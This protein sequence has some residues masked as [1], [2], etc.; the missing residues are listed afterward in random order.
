M[1]GVCI[2][3]HPSEL[4]MSDLNYVRCLLIPSS[5]SMTYSVV[6]FLRDCGGSACQACGGSSEVGA[7]W[8]G[9]EGA[10]SWAIRY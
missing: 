8:G 3:R 7:G 4:R 9:F 1:Q 10:G 5:A 2:S 6:F